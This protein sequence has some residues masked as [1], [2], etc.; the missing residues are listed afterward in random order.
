M[1]LSEAIEHNLQLSDLHPFLM[2]LAGSA[3]IAVILT[4]QPKSLAQLI[5]RAE[6]PPPNFCV[7]TSISGPDH[8][9]LQRVEDLKSINVTTRGILIDPM[10]SRIPPE[11]LNLDGIHWVIVSGQSDNTNGTCPF[12]LS[13]AEEL[14]DYCKEKGVAFF[15]NQIADPFGADWDEWDK[16]L[17]IRE[18]PEAFR[19]HTVPDLESEQ[20]DIPLVSGGCT[21][22]AA[23]KLIEV[24]IVTTASS[25][26]EFQRLDKIVREGIKNFISAGKALVEIKDNELWKES[27]QNWP[28]YCRSIKGL[29]R[30]DA[31]RYIKAGKIVIE[32]A[33]QSPI[34]DKSSIPMPTAPAQLRPL[35]LLKDASQWYPAWSKAVSMADGDVPTEEQV[36]AVVNEIRYPD[37]PPKSQVTPKQ[38]R[39]ELINDLTN[40]LTI[41]GLLGE[42]NDILMKLEEAA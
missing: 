15:L 13:W 34:G 7:L 17:K 5:S 39:I 40:A 42:F 18:Y 11:L 41:K 16:A 8:D 28:A 33:N 36:K 24:E 22:N 12:E 3:S 2:P 19:S 23:N 27:F 4:N 14:R 35:G 6:C 32:L 1:V 9:G 21:N 26:S 31:Y 10:I 20:E 38:R 37:G 25:E 29:G 30:S